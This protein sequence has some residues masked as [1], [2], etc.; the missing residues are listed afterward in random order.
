MF[1][2]LV[3][4]A[5]FGLMISISLYIGA[6]WKL[7]QDLELFDK[8]LG[9]SVKFDYESSVLTLAGN[10]VLGGV[11]LD[12]KQLDII[13][14]INSMEFS[15]GSVIDMAFLGSQ[16]NKQ[17]IP[18]FMSVSLDDV[19]IPLSPKLV[20]SIASIELQDNWKAM[21]AVGCGNVKML[22]INQY[23]AMGYDYIIFSSKM[24]FERDDYNGNLVGSGHLDIDETTIFDYQ[25][26]FSGWYENQENKT[27]K[28]KLPSL[29]SI[30]MKIQDNGYNLTRNEYCAVKSNL[31]VDEY[32]EQHTEK[33]KEIFESVD[34]KMTPTGLRNYKNYLQPK[35]IVDVS[36]APKASFTIAGFGFYDEAELRDLLG[37]NMTINGQTVGPIFNSWSHD[38]YSKI[39]F[40]ERSGEESELTN[41]RFEMVVV[42]RSFQVEPVSNIKNVIDLQV[43]VTRTDGKVV[44]GKLKRIENNRAYF[45]ILRDGGTLKMSVD[46]NEIKE[47]EVYRIDS[48]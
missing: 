25:F 41:K 47:L 24:K 6:Q 33:V 8:K 12:F 31:T 4:T 23:F 9:P 2:L 30:S 21:S 20:K 38:K 10:V 16:L 14:S 42:H 29:N 13:I 45:A 37:L 43:R 7:K 5:V 32:V 36:I 26:D 28:T 3:R 19:V 35:S 40:T 15:I 48:E 22:G 11:S 39:I 34:I 1:R 27:S 18:E 46:I 44:E 17:A